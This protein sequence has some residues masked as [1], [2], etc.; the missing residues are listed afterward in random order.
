M[1]VI[2]ALCVGLLIGHFS[3]AR[4]RTAGVLKVVSADEDGPYLFLELSKNV[5]EVTRKKYATFVVD[6]QTINP[7]K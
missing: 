1:E 2:I 7:Q 3:A 4:L 6:K 5:D